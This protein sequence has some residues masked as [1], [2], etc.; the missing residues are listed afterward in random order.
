MATL[1]K[2]ELE[3]LKALKTALAARTNATQ[4]ALAAYEKVGPT[5]IHTPWRRSHPG[6]LCVRLFVCV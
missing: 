2:A 1:E 6:R 5:G 4:H 3:R